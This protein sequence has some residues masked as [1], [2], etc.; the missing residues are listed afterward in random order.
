M[1]IRCSECGVEIEEGEF[2]TVGGMVITKLGRIPSKEEVIE[3]NGF[4][5]KVNKKDGHRINSFM[6]TRTK[7]NNRQ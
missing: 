6:A 7:P 3:F 4:S 5:L 2:E 1:A